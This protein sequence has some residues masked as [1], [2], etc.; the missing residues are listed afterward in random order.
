[1]Q[2]GEVL[3]PFPL[4]AMLF[5]FG[6]APTLGQPWLTLAGSQVSFMV[7]DWMEVGRGD[8]QHAQQ[9]VLSGL[10]LLK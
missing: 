6:N 2:P 9:E 10:F 4:I 8:T 1:M 7:K 3:G 5:G